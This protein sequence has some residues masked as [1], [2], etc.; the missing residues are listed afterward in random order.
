MTAILTNALRLFPRLS[1]SALVLLFALAAR[2][3]LPAAQ[4]PYAQG[5]LWQVERP[6]VAP[7]Y[8]FGTIHITDE[9]VLDL[10]P[11][12]RAAFE[13]ARS[14]TFEVIMTDEVRIKMA[15]AMVLNDG[16]TLESI[17]GPE[18]YEETVAAGRRYGI[19][20]ERLRHFKPWAL[21]T[22]FSI[23]QAELARTSSGDLPLDQWLQAEAAR[24]GKPLHAL[25]SADEQIA[26]FNDLAEA[27]QVA[28]LEAAVADNAAIEAMFE[29]MTRLYLARDVGA[30][31]AKMLA[32]SG[33]QRPRILELFMLRFNEARNAVMVERMAERLNEGGAFIAIGALHLPGETG[34]LSL[35]ERRGY[36][37]TRLY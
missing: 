23:P 3:A 36:R 11:P 37:L 33:S 1:L 10:P 18:L 26:L 30:I 31:V 14:A 35:L 22:I 7:N 28:L 24:R 21:A 17:L 16:R 12:V 27:D 9:R 19:G 8:L 34:L 4:Q 6:G 2:P 13:A 32:D 25:E 5:L 20:P 29:E 15:R